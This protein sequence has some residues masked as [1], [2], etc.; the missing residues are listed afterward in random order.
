MDDGPRQLWR[1]SSAEINR[2]KAER[3]RRRDCAGRPFLCQSPVSDRHANVL[4][5]K[6]PDRARE[7]HSL[8][9]VAGTQANQS[10]LPP[11]FRLGEAHRLALTI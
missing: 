1:G 11:R 10:C 2:E 3:G 4:A 8:I 9:Y 7:T 6:S 5:R